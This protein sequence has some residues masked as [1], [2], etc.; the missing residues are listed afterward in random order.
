[1]IIAMFCTAVLVWLLKDGGK[2]ALSVLLLAAV[3]FWAVLVVFDSV[4]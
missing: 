4:D 2:K 1:M 3:L